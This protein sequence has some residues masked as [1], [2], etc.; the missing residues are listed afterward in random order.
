MPEPF[1]STGLLLDRSRRNAY[2]GTCFAFRRST[3]FLTAAHCVEG[4]T[5]NQ[6]GLSI[7]LE[8]QP[9]NDGVDVLEVVRHPSADI[10]VV[11]VSPWLGELF[12][13]YRGV[14]VGYRPGDHFAAFGYPEDT[15]GQADVA[16]IP[17]F[18]RGHFHRFFEYRSPLGYSYVA[19]E[20][21]IG[22][23]AGL[24]GG[25]VFLPEYPDYVV[26]VVAENIES[27]THRRTIE[28][29]VVSGSSTFREVVRSVIDYGICVMLDE[30]REWL[31]AY[32]PPVHSNGA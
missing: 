3:Y 16:P 5:T 20:L 11:R 27:S 14:T 9:D 12:P 23:P 1:E 13:P 28:E 15:T 31:D 29:E 18:F 6:I 8:G 32:I 19:G 21:S 25:P 24:S 30:V 26:G 4:L 7:Y 10:A 2:L 22:T 17:R